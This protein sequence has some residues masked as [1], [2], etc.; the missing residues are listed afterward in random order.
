[1]RYRGRRGY[2]RTSPPAGKY[3]WGRWWNWVGMA[4]ILLGLPLIPL[5]IGVPIFFVGLV[6]ALAGL[7]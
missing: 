3:R 6:L 1:M 2:Y 4:L 5:L 7:E